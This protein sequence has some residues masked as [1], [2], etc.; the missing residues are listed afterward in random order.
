MRSSGIIL[1]CTSWHLATEPSSPPLTAGF[2]FCCMILIDSFIDCKEIGCSYNT[3]GVLK[4][5]KWG[6]W[7]RKKQSDGNWFRLT[8]GNWLHGWWPFI[9]HAPAVAELVST[10]CTLRFTELIRSANGPRP[11][12]FLF[13]AY[14]RHQLWLAANQ[15]W[16]AGHMM[17]SGLWDDK[18]IR[19]KTDLYGQNRVCIVFGVVWQ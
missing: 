5:M 7:P 16:H 4:V 11:V 18:K 9:I 13:T 19:F 14:E 3:A 15:H 10:Y 17:C 6:T 8:P 12:S 1:L 2:S